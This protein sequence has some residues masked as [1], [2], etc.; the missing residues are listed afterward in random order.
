M[1]PSNLP[2]RTQNELDRIAQLFEVPDEQLRQITEAFGQAFNKG[3]QVP[4]QAVVMG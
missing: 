3:L 4:H 2:L 1:A